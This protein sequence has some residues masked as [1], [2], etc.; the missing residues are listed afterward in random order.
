MEANKITVLSADQATRSVQVEGPIKGLED[1]FQVK[2]FEFTHTRGNFRGRTGMVHIPSAAR[3][4][5]HGV[6]GLDNR[7]V[8]RRE[9]QGPDRTSAR[10]TGRQWRC[11][12]GL[13]PRAARRG[14]RLPPRRRN[15]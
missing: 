3:R 4:G 11:T 10:G 14:L 8:I 6:Y 2:L 13:R 15:G 7:P 9:P 1:V 5:C 12:R